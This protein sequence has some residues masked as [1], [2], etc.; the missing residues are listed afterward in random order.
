MEFAKL[1]YFEGKI[2]PFAEA[3]VS[4]A[5]HAFLYGTAVFEGIRGF[6]NEGRGEVFVFRLAEH[7]ERLARN[8]R[9]LKMT[10][11]LSVEKSAQLVLEL[12]RQNE[13]RADLYIR[14]VLYKSDRRFGVKLF[15]QQDLTIIV[16]A[17]GEY[18]EKPEGID[19]CVSSWRRLEDNALPGRGKI[20]GAYVNSC[21]AGDEARSNGFDEAILLNEDGH[22][23]EA[24]GMNLFLVRSGRLI[25][26][27][28]T[29]N[30]LEGITRDS[31]LTLARK[32]LAIEC[33]I[34]PVDRTELYVADELFICGTA[35]K[36]VS[37]RSVDRRPVGDGATGPITRR[38][39]DLYSAAVR[40][41]L[42]GYGH[43]VTPVFGGKG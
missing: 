22:V 30:I 21:L 12:L 39:G 11:P 43:W 5:T 34:R 36:L 32:E 37:A 6:L 19:L 28:V 7:M 23:S 13:L 3:R 15:A 35:A 31:V 17:M 38:L 41:E 42:K 10:L 29:E 24:S 8:A 25:T 18:M 16:A 20:N 40:A 9:L 14:P 2:V 1:A 4:V 26:T 33:E 27:P